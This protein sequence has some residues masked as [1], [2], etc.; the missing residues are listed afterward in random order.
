MNPFLAQEVK[1]PDGEFDV[2]EHGDAG[3]LVKTA[4][5][6]KIGN[7]TVNKISPADG[8]DITFDVWHNSILNFVTGGGLPPI[9]YKKPIIVE[10]YSNDGISVIKTKMYLGCWPNKINGEDLNRKGSEN[11]MNSIEFCID[12]VAP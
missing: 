4:G 7:I 8:P 2:V 5:L 11:T 3:Y 12:T 10:Q 6:R 9:G 1:T